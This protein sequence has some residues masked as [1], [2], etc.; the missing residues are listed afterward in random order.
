MAQ[1]CT[2]GFRK[3]GAGVQ[4]AIRKIKIR[5]RNVL[6]VPFPLAMELKHEAQR[7]LDLSRAFDGLVRDAQPL[8]VGLTYR[9]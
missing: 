6:P 3:V 2:P 5:E 4:P 1:D 7:H 8:S 9:D